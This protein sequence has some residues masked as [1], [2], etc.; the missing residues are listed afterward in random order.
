MQMLGASL[1]SVNIVQLMPLVL[2]ISLNILSGTWT[3]AQYRS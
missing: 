2:E 3:A 1:K